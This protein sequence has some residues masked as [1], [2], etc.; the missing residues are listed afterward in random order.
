M[1]Y[2]RLPVRRSQPWLAGVL[3]APLTLAGC[4]ADDPDE[5]LPRGVHPTLLVTADRKEQ[6]TARLDREPYATILTE[7][8]ERADRSYEEPDPAVWDHAVIGRNNETA[9]A[10]AMLAWL[11][12]DEARAAKAREFLL[13]MPTDFETNDTWD[14]NIRMPHVL[15]PYVCARDLLLGTPWLSD[16]D[17]A[18]MAGRVTA[19]N[20]KFFDKFLNNEAIRQLVLGVSQN[21]HPIRTAS[22]IAMVAIAFPEHPLADEWAGWAVSE[23]DYLLGEDGRYIQPDGGVSEG[24]H[25]YAFALTPALAL[26]IAMDNAVDPARTFARDCRNRQTT[27]PWNVTDCTDGESFTFDN[28]LFSERLRQTV[29]WSINLRMPGGWRAPLADSY[30]TRFSGGAL[31]TSFSGQGHLRWDWEN[32]PEPVWPMTSGLDLIPYHLVY[33]D[34]SV[35][36]N[37]PPWRNRFLPDAG[38]AVFRSG[39]S[40]DAVWLLLVAE[41]GPARMTLHDHVDGTSLSLAAYGDYLLVDPGYYKPDDLDNAVTAHSDS[42]NTVRIDGHGAPDKGLL[43]NFGD[44]DAFLRNTVDGE[45][46]AYAEAHQSYESTDIERSVTFVRQRYFVVADRLATTVATSRP[47]AWRLGGWAGYD[48]GGTFEP[49]DCLS[50]NRCGV[51]IARDHGGV[52]VHLASTAPGLH[53]VEPPYTPL[54]APH[55][56]E[57]DRERTQEDH[58]VIDGEVDG[59]APGFLAVLAPYRVGASAG[60]PDG[61]L[62]VTAI[63][64]GADA[65]A[66]LIESV[67]GTDVAWLRK[68]GAAAT[69]SLPGGAQLATDAELVVVDVNG[70]FGLIARGS[71]ASVDGTPVVEG[72]GADGVVKEEP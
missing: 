47:H 11:L 21:N 29:D 72:D 22:S 42:H 28:P 2:H 56:G 69:L 61:P 8:T 71:T 31:L 24:P 65:A 64:A 13:R 37:E 27:E 63:D 25:Y 20:E 62:T 51:R 55:V 4:S 48:S 5:P 45:A 38:N 46:L 18:D 35:T 9:Q 67:A 41:N 43:T 15:I 12:D 59:V 16:A 23:L 6:V 49:W 19:V 44:A 50:P 34:D 1:R 68:A 70:S 7:L 54:A 58:G 26:M 40:D 14:V 30:F 53:V 60:E 33:V 66:W 52:E 32:Q 39:W 57:F 17:A 3:A 10:S 36:P